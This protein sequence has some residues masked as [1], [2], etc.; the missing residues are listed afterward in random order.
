VLSGIWTST[1]AG[2]EG[3]GGGLWRRQASRTPRNIALAA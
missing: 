2:A 1:A 3:A